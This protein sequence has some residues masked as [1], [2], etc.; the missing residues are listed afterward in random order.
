[1]GFYDHI[2]APW[3]HPFAWV[4]EGIWA[5]QSIRTEPKN[6]QTFWYNL[7]RGFCTFL[8]HVVLIFK[9]KRILVANGY[10]LDYPITVFDF[11]LLERRPIWFHPQLDNSYPLSSI[12]FRVQFSTNGKKGSQSNELGFQHF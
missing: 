8:K 10:N 9:Q 2:S 5:G 4:Y 11:Y 1:M 3:D 12:L 7:A 6:L